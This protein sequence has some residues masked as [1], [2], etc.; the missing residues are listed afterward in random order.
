[1]VLSG[2]KLAAG[3]KGVGPR[4]IQARLKADAE[5]CLL[6]LESGEKRSVAGT[7]GV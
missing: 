1:M 2:L 4:A 7:Y 5:E 6:Y 3:T